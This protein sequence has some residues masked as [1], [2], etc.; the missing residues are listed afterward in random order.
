MANP[1]DSLRA[2]IEKVLNNKADRPEVARAIFDL[3]DHDVQEW[4]IRCHPDG[5]STAQGLA[6]EEF[7]QKVFN[8]LMTGIRV[9]NHVGAFPYAF[10][11][12]LTGD[13]LDKLQPGE[14]ALRLPQPSK[15]RRTRPS[16][17]NTTFTNRILVYWYA[18]QLAPRMR[19]A[20]E[21][22]FVRQ[23]DIAEIARIMHHGT[24]SSA[25]SNLRQG[26]GHIRLYAERER[27][28][29]TPRRSKRTKP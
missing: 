12:A 11:H 2:L 19:Q 1:A 27:R 23:L 28:G 9:M 15:R 24:R 20:L 13:L 6:Y 5:T 17:C 4:W 25:E 10:I 29:L 7:R 22:R 3:L 26:V 21:L 14:G 16:N 8:D 18:D